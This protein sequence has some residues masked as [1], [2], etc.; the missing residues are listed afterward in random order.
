MRTNKM[1]S[2]EAA[3]DAP[4][5]ILSE[6]KAAAEADPAVAS[7]EGAS[8]APGEESPEVHGREC[9][10]G[11]VLAGLHGGCGWAVGRGAG[12]CAV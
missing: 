3:D 7:P 6:H 10:C 5:S 8:V 11:R 1:A 2:N 4:P 12:A 9:R